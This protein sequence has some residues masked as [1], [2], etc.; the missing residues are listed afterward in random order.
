MKQK[1][2]TS[3]CLLFIAVQTYAQKK[4]VPQKVNLTW[5]I[6][7]TNHKN[8]GNTLSELVLTNPSS[9]PFPASGWKI[10]FNSGNPRNA[11]IDSL[12]LKITHLNGDL[13][14]VTPSKSFKGIAPKQSVSVK[15]LSRSLKN[16]TDYSEGFYIVYDSQPS[17]PVVLSLKNV[18]KVDYTEQEKVIAKQ[19]YEQNKLR[20][21]IDAFNLKPILPTPLNYENGGGTFR[22]TNNPSIIADPIFEKERE[23]FR[24]ELEKVLTDGRE[25]SSKP[26][27]NATKGK[28]EADIDP[29][30]ITVA[31]LTDEKIILKLDENLAAEAYVLEIKAE[32]ITIFA[33]KPAGA[34][35]GI[36]T[37]KSLM[38]GTAWKAKQTRIELPFCKVTDEPRFPHRAFMM[39][40]SRNFQPKV[41]ILKVL[42]VLS[43]Y[44]INVF[45][46]HFNDDEGWRIEIEG[47]PELTQVGGR[48]GH[49]LTE[50]AHL[51]PSYGSG[52]N[53]SNPYGSG[54]LSKADFIEILKYAT[55]RHIK[56]I[57]EYETPG[58]A[59]A[60]IKAMDARYK[61]LIKAGKS[62]E[63]K[64]YLLRDLQDRSV[65]RSVQGFS[66]NVINPALPSVYN[67]IGKIIDETVAMYKAAGAPLHTIHF[68]GDEVPAGVWEKSPAVEA[69]LAKD[70][71]IENVDELWHY[72]FKNVNAL[73]KAKGL[74]LSG[75]EE[76]GLKKQLVN[77]KKQMVL[78]TRF[79][80]E[81]FHT[82]VWNNLKGNE[83]LAY[84]LANAGYKV[85]L[86]NVTNMYLDLAYNKDY[87][88][89]GQYW[90]GYVDVDKP[91][92]F[93]PFDYYSNQTEDQY[94]NPLPANYYRDMDKL[95][96]NAKANIIGLQAPLWSEVLHSK[97]R[98]E[99]LF[100]PKILGLAE[101]AWAKDPA[102]NKIE[103]ENL[104]KRLY[105]YDWST[106]VN[107]ISKNELPR[108]D[109]YAGGFEYRIPTPGYIVKDDKVEANV[110]YPDL[111]IRYTVDGSE[112]NAQSP[113]YTTSIPY[114]NNIKLR[115]FNNEGRG[116]RTVKVVK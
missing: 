76:I 47:L 69:L 35:Y 57:P 85:V 7:E 19:I 101:R 106:F 100:L 60:A 25:D 40:I 18:S 77:G 89:I 1:L 64:Q 88:E 104:R 79:V 99:Y 87:N 45:H 21:E 43:F 112:P 55:A 51:F 113:K 28:K 67:F 44:K 95:N 83:D 30:E 103:H 72:Y 9:T 4:M 53:V 109:Y 93:T 48:R 33:A 42:D 5:N 59:R 108:L 107:R 11:E 17:K 66:D 12:S 37:L 6:L 114:Q 115:V 97:E 90:G 54:H 24:A 22:L 34:F 16:I 52:P 14:T 20:S 102:W 74:Y 96:E 98:F 27:K 31:E 46:L 10:Y 94:G 38:P 91:F 58:H 13:F 41:Q 8:T 26:K 81:N 29:S 68:G 2:F 36:Q 23:Y 63:A 116:S 15:I 110:L 86:T 65:Y 82:D 32:G 78:D 3:F 105:K 84:K 49:T 39:D 111:T 71:S 73:L 62:K 61:R 92:N 80:N 75:W 70:K 56:I 50:D